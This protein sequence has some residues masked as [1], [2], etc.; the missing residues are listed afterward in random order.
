MDKEIND[1][2][3]RCKALQGQTVLDIINSDRF[4]DNL[5]GYWTAQRED[6]K[7]IKKSYAAMY[8]VG[9]IHGYKLPAHCIDK[10]MDYG[11]EQLRDEYTK[12]VAK[13]STLPAA[14]RA[15][16]WQLGQQAYALTVAQIVC[17]EFPE[18]RE[19]LIPKSKAN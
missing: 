3:S 17:E 15:Y 2:I 4:R 12:V 8:K 7:A 14:Q 19:K 6:R 1:K 10:L 13:V 5:A 18:L 9:S 11:V 16:I